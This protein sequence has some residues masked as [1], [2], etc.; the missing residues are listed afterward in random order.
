MQDKK[1]DVSCNCGQRLFVYR[2][3]GKGRLIKLF[4]SKIVESTA[5]FDPQNAQWLCPSCQCVCGRESLI[6]G[7]PAIK[8]NQGAIRKIVV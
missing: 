3:S 8:L 1:V 4:K 6:N 7:Q 2:K 5:F